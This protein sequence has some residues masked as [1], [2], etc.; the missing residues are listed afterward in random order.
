MAGAEP[1]DGVEGLVAERGVASGGCFRWPHLIEQGVENA[2]IRVAAN[3]GVDADKVSLCC[4][5][6]KYPDG[7]D[8]KM[9]SDAVSEVIVF[10][11]WPVCG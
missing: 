6:R 8:C 7:F 4:P 1:G 9:T 11:W 5:A 2:E 10:V 3:W